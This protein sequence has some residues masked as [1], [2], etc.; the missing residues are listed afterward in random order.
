MTWDLK[1]STAT[2]TTD[3][4]AASFDGERPFRGLRIQGQ[5]EANFDARLFAFLLSEPPAETYVRGDDL[6]SKYPARNS[7]LV[8]YTT[9]HRRIASKETLAYEGIQFILSAQT[10]LLDS[11]P[12]TQIVSEFDGAQL[13]FKPSSGGDLRSVEGELI[14][15][16][17]TAPQFFLIR[18]EADKSHSFVLMIHPTDFHRGSVRLDPTP[19]VALHVFPEALEKGVIRR[20][21][22][23]CCRVSR[24]QDEKI[25]A[26]LFESLESAAP[27]LTV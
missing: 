3:A 23:K 24:D 7:D 21:T 13:F 15:D 25:A 12:L 8:S 4:F 27:P 22:L 5:G 10:Y 2:L 19:A 9:Y 14:F 16:A 18:S 11:A 20:A 17:T 6:V 1:D 26:Q